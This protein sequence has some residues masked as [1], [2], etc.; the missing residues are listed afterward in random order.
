MPIRV[1]AFKAIS[2]LAGHAAAIVDAPVDPVPD[3]AHS[4]IIA[5]DALQAEWLEASFARRGCSRNS[6]SLDAA[7]AG[8]E[9]LEAM[10]TVSI[11]AA[12]ARIVDQIESLSPRA[13]TYKGV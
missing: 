9:I 7:G 5:D 2:V 1:W 12:L 13:S 11:G 4:T 6:V 8:P 3:S 10:H